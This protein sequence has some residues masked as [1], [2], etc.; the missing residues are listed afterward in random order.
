MIKIYSEKKENCVVQVIE[1][2]DSDFDMK[3]ADKLFG[4]F[5]RLHEIAEFEGTGVDLALGH[6]VVTRHVGR[7]WTEAKVNRGAKVFFSLPYSNHTP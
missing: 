3:Y 4:A 7:V 6:K 2:N 5:Q 1:G